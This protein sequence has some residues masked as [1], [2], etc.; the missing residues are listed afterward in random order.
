MPKAIEV[1]VSIHVPVTLSIVGMPQKPNACGIAQ[2]IR[3]PM[4]DRMVK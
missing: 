4:G 3:L 2:K 1:E